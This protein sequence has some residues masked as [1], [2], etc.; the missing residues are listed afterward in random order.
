MRSISAAAG[1]R[2]SPRPSLGT[3][4]TTRRKCIDLIERALPLFRDEGITGERFSDTIDRLGFDYVEDKLLNE[5][6]EKDSI[7]EKKVTGGAT[8]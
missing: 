4:F 2:R 8:C 3:L 6:I 5:K 1:A 7:L